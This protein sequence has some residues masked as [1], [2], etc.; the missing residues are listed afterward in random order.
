MPLKN[1]LPINSHIKPHTQLTLQISAAPAVSSTC[2]WAQGGSR[3]RSSA[4][5]CL[6]RDGVEGIEDFGG[7]FAVLCEMGPALTYLGRA[8]AEVRAWEPT[9]VPVLVTVFR[10]S[11]EG[12]KRRPHPVWEKRG[13]WVLVEGFHWDLVPAIPQMALGLDICCI[14]QIII[15]FL[16]STFSKMPMTPFELTG[17][18][19]VLTEVLCFLCFL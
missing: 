13:C 15:T 4:E 3:D 8:G 7:I 9:E 17:F 12:G 2:L 11:G 5:L 16:K 6:P 19:R 10:P 18:T 14:L 1:S